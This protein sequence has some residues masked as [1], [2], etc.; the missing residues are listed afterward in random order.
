MD[1]ERL[2][3]ALLRGGLRPPARRRR[4]SVRRRAGVPRLGRA[5][6]GMTLLGAAVEAFEHFSKHKT[7]A[8]PGT[9]AGATPLAGGVPPP[10]PPPPTSG[11][12]REKEAVLLVR[13]MIAA[14]S[15]D[16]QIDADEREAILGSLQE[17]QLGADEQNFVLREMLKPCSVDELVAGVASP[18][19]AE[20]VYAAAVCAIEV[21]TDAEKAFLESLRKGLRIDVLRAQAIEDDALRD[22]A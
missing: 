21:D 20:Q 12:S 9:A 6:I 19:L 11:G 22:Q 4:R 17:A 3:G 16:G 5:A 15:A 7:L 8:A 1:A 10:P 14:A 18:E 2:L 13:A